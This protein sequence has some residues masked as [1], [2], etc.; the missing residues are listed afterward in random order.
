MAQLSDFNPKTQQQIVTQASESGWTV[1]Y[2]IDTY[3]S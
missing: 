3:Y 2:L 1:Q